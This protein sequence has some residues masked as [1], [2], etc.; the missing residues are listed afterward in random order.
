[1]LRF[2]RKRLRKTGELDFVGLCYSAKGGEE[3]EG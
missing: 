2:D 3:Y 1:M